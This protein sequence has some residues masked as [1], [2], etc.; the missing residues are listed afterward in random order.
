MPTRLALSVLALALSSVLTRTASAEPRRFAIDPAVS[1]F[2]VHVGKTGIFGFAGHEHE[3]VA[4][5]HDGAVILDR[6]HLESSSVEL[7]FAAAALHVT[8]RGEPPDDVP[9]VQAAM[10]GPECLDAERF[11]TIRFVSNR[12][13]VTANAGASVD[14]VVSGVLN[15]HGVSREVS[16]PV[17]L[18]LTEDTIRATGGTRLQQTAFGIQPISVGGV[19]KVKDELEL[20]WHLQAR[21]AH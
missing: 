15:I 20:D 10:V 21:A 17:R 14:V 18:V 5:I 19:V 16:I 2:V 4:P 1:H 11:R 3:V 8:G 7:T 13:Q 6:D 12:V 9:K